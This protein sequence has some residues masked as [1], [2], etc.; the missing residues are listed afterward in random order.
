MKLRFRALLAALLYACVSHAANAT[1]ITDWNLTGAPGSQVSQLANSAAGNVNGQ[2]ITRGAGIVAV[3]AANSL[4]SNAWTQQTT[5]YV[6][7]GFSV[8]AGYSVDLSNLIIG[9]QSSAT[10]PGTMGLFYSGDNFTT[11]LYSFT[12]PS[13]SLLSSTVNLSTLTGLTGNVEF[14]LFQVGTLAPNGGLT[15]STGTFRLANAVINT[16][17]TNIQFNGTVN[18]VSAVPLPAAFGLFAAGLGLFG[19]AARR[20][21]AA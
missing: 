14:R 17:N 6:S 16:I 10:G 5:D 11:N 21:K 8:N 15:A 4:S 7:F 20:R 2:A 3:A 12:Q 13:A 19:A 1:L 9:T 18:P